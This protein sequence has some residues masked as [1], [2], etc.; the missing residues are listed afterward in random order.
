MPLI[1]TLTLRPATPSDRPALVEQEL[2]LN[3]FEDAIAHDRNLTRPGADAAIDRLFERI[4]ESDGTV[5]VADLNGAVI[6][7]MFL[8]FDRMGPY[9]REDMRD[10]ALVADMFVRAAHRGQGIA[11]ALLAEAERL[12]TARGVPR[13]MIGVLSGNDR[14]ER[15]YQEFGFTPYALELTK[16]LPRG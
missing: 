1:P 4:A 10:Y 9:V 13:L 15:T 3:L 14:A 6:A 2:L 7:H 16:S 11:Q 8:V 5:I 12:A